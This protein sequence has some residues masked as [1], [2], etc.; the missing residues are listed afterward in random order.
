MTAKYLRNL[1]PIPLWAATLGTVGL[2]LTLGA[3]PAW[4]AGEGSAN[5][6]MDLLWKTINVVVLLGL[7]HVFARKPLLN[8]FRGAASGLKKGLQGT[9]DAAA[10]AESEMVEQKRKIEGLQAELERLV[11]EARQEAQNERDRLVAEARA[12]TDRIMEQMRGQVE[13]EFSKAR[14]ALRRQLADETLQL[15]EKMIVER[16]DD[17]ARERL[18]GT[19]IEQLGSSS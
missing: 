16:L 17:T 8:F 15:A 3:A 12:Q 10:K 9:R 11:V 18:V 7:L 5:P 4:A 1:A 6:W 14:I 13:Q 2:C 19:T